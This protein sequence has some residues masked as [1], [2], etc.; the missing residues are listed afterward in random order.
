MH[1]TLSPWLRWI[2]DN[3]RAATRRWL[4]VGVICAKGTGRSMLR[5]GVSSMTYQRVALP[6]RNDLRTRRKRVAVQAAVHAEDIYQRLKSR[7]LGGVCLFR[8]VFDRSESA[9][10][11]VG[12]LG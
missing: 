1:A 11:S 8:E 4:A 7:V 3:G 9:V 5:R 6:P 10:P 2:R 12:H